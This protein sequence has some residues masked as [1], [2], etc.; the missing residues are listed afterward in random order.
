MKTYLLAAAL[1]LFSLPAFADGISCREM[2]QMI[3]DYEH[4]KKAGGMSK[5]RS[6]S[7]HGLLSAS[8]KSYY[9]SGCTEAELQRHFKSGEKF[10]SK[11]EVK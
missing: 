9:G 7:V 11:K 8:Y 2:S 10:K 1:A 3:A 6:E 5:V 4:E